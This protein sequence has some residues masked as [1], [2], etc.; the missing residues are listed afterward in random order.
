MIVCPNLT[1]TNSAAN[2][3]LSGTTYTFT[4]SSNKTRDKTFCY[5]YTPDLPFCHVQNRAVVL[6]SLVGDLQCRRTTQIKQIFSSPV[7]GVE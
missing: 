2:Y 7:V 3:I 4:D 1:A 5:R 6:P